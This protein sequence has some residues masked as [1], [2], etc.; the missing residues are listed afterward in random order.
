[1][2][3]QVFKSYIDAVIFSAIMIWMITLVFY[4]QWR[5]DSGTVQ[6]EALSGAESFLVYSSKEIFYVFSDLKII[7]IG[8]YPHL[9]HYIL[10]NPCN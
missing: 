6:T 5:Q 9:L 1:M 2:K 7:F 4:W 10:P 3:M 8:G